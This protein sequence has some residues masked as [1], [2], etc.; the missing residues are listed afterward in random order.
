MELNYSAAIAINVP[1][2][3]AGLSVDITS[4]YLNNEMGIT[5][6]DLF[7]ETSILG[8]IPFEGLGL[9]C[10]SEIQYK[11]ST[12]FNITNLVPLVKLGAEAGSKHIFEVHVTDLAGQ[13]TVQKL[14]FQIPAAPITITYN[15]LSL[16]HI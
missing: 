13:E 14:T 7:N 8:A 12:I 1:G 9:A 2:G 6:L 10:T 15:D 16:I 4:D 11:K 3:I 5:T